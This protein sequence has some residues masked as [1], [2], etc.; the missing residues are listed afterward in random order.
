MGMLTVESG[1]ARAPST[2][3]PSLSSGLPLALLSAAALG[4]NRE[5]EEAVVDGSLPPFLP[6]SFF[7]FFSAD[8]ESLLFCA[9]GKKGSVYFHIVWK[10]K[11][12]PTNLNIVLRLS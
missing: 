12:I 1:C 4:G 9:S 3:S 6:I 2:S 7:F 8:S 5:E 11:T 10:V